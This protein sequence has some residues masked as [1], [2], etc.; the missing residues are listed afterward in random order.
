MPRSAKPTQ[1][2][3]TRFDR[4]ED[5]DV[6]AR[7]ANAGRSMASCVTAWARCIDADA[8]L[9]LFAVG[10]YGRGELFPQSDVDLL[11]LADPEAQQA[12]PDT[13][14]RACSRCCGTPACRWAMPCVRRP[15]CTQAAIADITVLTALLEARPLAARDA[16]R[17]RVVCIDRSRG[18]SGR[19]ASTSS[20]SARSSARA[21]RASTTPATTSNPTSRKARAACATCRRCGGWR[22]A[23][24]A[25][26]ASSR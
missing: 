12:A 1:P 3:P 13:R 8:P 21:M 9:S 14:S 4:G 18:L 24:W 7:R 15:Q 26:T 6:A 11:V 10:G 19:R 23:C 16:R 2:W 22:C 5:V 17:Q 25:R 20:P